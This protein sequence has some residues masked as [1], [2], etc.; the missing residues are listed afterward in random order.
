MVF[1]NVTPERGLRQEDPISPYV[2][3]MCA[4]GLSSIL[5]RNEEAGLIHG[6]RISR[7]APTIS[8]V[9]FAGD[10]YLFFKA[11]KVEA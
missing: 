8:R 11:T 10:C 2:Y 7:V 3:I 4:K 6:C 5:G 1:G 9:L